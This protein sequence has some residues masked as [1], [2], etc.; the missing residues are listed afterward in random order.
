MGI[1]G[2]LHCSFVDYVFH[3]Y[4]KVMSFADGPL[5]STFVARWCV[6]TKVETAGGASRIGGRGRTGRRRGG[7]TVWRLSVRLLLDPGEENHTGVKKQAIAD[8]GMSD[9]QFQV[10]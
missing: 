5:A 6:G 10:L 7:K 1:R 2:S 9:R 4:A 3:A 8:G